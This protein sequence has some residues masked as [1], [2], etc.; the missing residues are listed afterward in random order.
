MKRLNFC[1]IATILVTVLLCSCERDFGVLDVTNEQTVNA[2]STFV[3]IGE[4]REMANRFLSNLTGKAEVTRGEDA[5]CL[6]VQENGTTVMYVINYSGGG[7]VVVGATKDYYPILAY[8]DKNYFE[9]PTENNGLSE[10]LDETKKAVRM[11]DSFSDSIKESMKRL[12]DIY[13]SSPSKAGTAAKTRSTSYSSGQMACWEKCD[14]LQ[15]ANGADGWYYMPLSDAKHVFDDAG[16]N[17]T[18]EN[19]C[20]GADFNNSPYECSV[21]GY[22]YIYKTDIVGPLLTAKWH[23]RAPFN[24][25]CDG[26]PA[27]CGAIAASQLMKY[28]QWPNS[29]NLDGYIFDWSNIPDSADANSDQS[30]LVK[31]VR[32]ILNTRH[33]L[34]YSYVTPGD[35]ED[36]LKMLLYDVTTSD[37]SYEKVEKELMTYKRP[38]IM[39]GNASNLPAYI[40]NSHYWVCD[41][42]KRLTT[43][44]MYYYT[45]WQP[46][47][48]GTFTTGW[49]T[50]NQP[51]V[52]GG[53]IYLYFSMNW[54]WGGKNDGWF[55]YNDVDSGEGNFKHS[56]KDYY[57]TKH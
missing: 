8:S 1:T 33:I 16:F 45:L 10:W 51:E 53:V 5:T 37:H 31:L 41:G 40:G 52:L 7:F 26:D 29:F 2:E 12:W 46:N 38:V 56:R 35:M 20:F 27:G 44:Q 13:Y 28:Y 6:T 22:K 9:M 47:G 30:A 57:I 19:I 32:G 34:D 49:G 42:A 39:L 18:Y 55:A 14:E 43:N 23:Q 24:D 3:S 48:E 11:S 54:G 4:A 15:M 36:G 25:L 17:G 21:V 50:L